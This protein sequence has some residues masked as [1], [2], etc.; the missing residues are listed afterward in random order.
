MERDQ[1][2]KRT[3]DIDRNLLIYPD[4]SGYQGHI[5]AS[6]YAP[7]IKSTQRR[8]LGSAES[9][10]VYAAEL[11]GIDMA[12]RLCQQL[13][14]RAGDRYTSAIIFTDSQAAIKS[15]RQP[16]R[17]SGLQIL[18]RILQAIEDLKS[19]L[20]VTI[21]WIPGNEAADKVAKNVVEMGRLGIAA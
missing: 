7:Q 18:G 6:A 19:T 1:T 11:V 10:T 20:P 15:I 12:T 5:G 8:H 2:K 14:D 9:T 13:R 16:S 4:G 3:C 21:Q 17:A